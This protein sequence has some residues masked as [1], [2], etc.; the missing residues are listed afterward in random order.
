MRIEKAQNIDS[1]YLTELT[2][3]SKAHWGYSSEQITKWK[4]DLTIYTDYIDQNEVY[5]LMNKNQLIGYYSYIEVKENTVKLDNIFLEPDFIG[6][7][8]GKMMMNH[9][10]LQVKDSG[11]EAVKLD[12]EPNTVKFY[13]NLGF[14]IVGRLESSIP[15]RFLPIMELD[16]SAKK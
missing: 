1:K 10:L 15:N 3:R 9:F 12:S 7:G 4:K 2:L 5:K 11:Y 8:Y 13:Q 16:I 6:K 14:K